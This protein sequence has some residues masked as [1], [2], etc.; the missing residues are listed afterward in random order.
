MN[1]IYHIDYHD[2]AC[3]WLLQ[4]PIRDIVLSLQ[5][6]VV[7]GDLLRDCIELGTADLKSLM[8]CIKD[9]AS[10]FFPTAPENEDFVLS[11]QKEVVDGALFFSTEPNN[12]L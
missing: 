11:L 12:D 7:D 10:T 9:I 2:V 5:K 6:E 4:G 3:G 1:S 8:Q